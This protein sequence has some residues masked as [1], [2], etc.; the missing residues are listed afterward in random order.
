MLRRQN[1][2]EYLA[3]IRQSRITPMALGS[4]RKAPDGVALVNKGDHLLFKFAWTK[5]G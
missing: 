5:L 3:C 4:Q 1:R 2:S